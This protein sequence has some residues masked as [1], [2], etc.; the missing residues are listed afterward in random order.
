DDY[1]ID[2]TIR[3]ENQTGQPQE[4][5]IVIPWFVRR[6]DKTPDEKFIGQRPTEVVWSSGGHV[7]RIDD[8]GSIGTRDMEGEWI[9]LDSTW[10]VAALLPKTPGFRLTAHGDF[11]SDAKNGIVTIAIRA[12]PTIA[13]GRVWTGRAEL[14]VGPKE[15]ERLVAH[16]LEGTLNF[17][18]F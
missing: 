14:Y 7:Y 1:A 12:T 17:G 4:V 8:L 5:A 18:G 16:S 2:A 10:Y 15:Y 13:P 11:A 3:I 9:G 6:H